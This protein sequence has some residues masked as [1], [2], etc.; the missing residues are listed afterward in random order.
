MKK[1]LLVLSA[2]LLSLFLSQVGMIFAEE[3]PAAGWKQALMNDRAQVK[4]E[5]LQIKENAA[6]AKTEELE[7]KKQIQA[8]VTAGDHATAKKLRE[9]L[10]A[11]HQENVRTRVQDKQ[12]LQSDLRELKSDR[13]EARK[14]NKLRLKIDKDNN[15]PGP[16]GGAGTNWENPPGPKGGVGASPNRRG[17][18]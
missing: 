9:Q 3:A 10:K 2:I 8:A 15:P 7:L 5:K 1:Y 14:E 16:A 4:E 11:M 12:E 17:N 18:R 6:A 13:V